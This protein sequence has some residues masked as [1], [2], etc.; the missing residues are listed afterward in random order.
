MEKYQETEE[1]TEQQENPHNFKMDLGKSVEKEEKAA[2]PVLEKRLM[3][4]KIIKE[5]I[6]FSSFKEFE[7]FIKKELRS[8]QDEE[9]IK[10]Y[11][12]KEEDE[13]P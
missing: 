2:K 8:N 10:K 5:E 13:K 6:R 9:I 11:L 7:I 3:R 1:V 12:R 4:E